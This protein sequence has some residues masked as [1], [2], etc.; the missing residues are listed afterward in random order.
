MTP[1]IVAIDMAFN[2]PYSVRDGTTENCDSRLNLSSADSKAL[3]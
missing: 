1:R 2:V 3:K